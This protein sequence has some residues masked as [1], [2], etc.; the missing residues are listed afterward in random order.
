VGLLAMTMPFPTV[1]YSH[2]LSCQ[3]LDGKRLTRSTLKCHVKH[4]W[5]ENPL[6]R[7]L[8][9]DVVCNRGMKALV[10]QDVGN[11]YDLTPGLA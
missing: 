7:S 9:R 10:C 11:P 2:M 8:L 6:R 1:I 5:C 4:I 3:G